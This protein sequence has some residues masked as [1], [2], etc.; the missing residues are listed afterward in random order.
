[1]A[2]NLARRLTTIVA[3]DVAGYSRLMAEDEEG[4]VRRFDSA[5]ARF[6]ALIAEHGGRIFNTAGDAVLAEFASAV[7]AARCALAVQAALEGQQAQT[8]AARRIRFRMGIHVGDVIPRGTDLLG[9]GVNVAARLQQMAP[10]GGIVIARTVS[11]QIEGKLALRLVDLGDQHVKN[12]PRPIRAYRVDGAGVPPP[13]DRRRLYA[14]LAGGGAA[15]LVL[16]AWLNRETIEAWFLPPPP[17]LPSEAVRDCPACPVMLPVRAGNFVMGAPAADNMGDD[18]ERPQRRVTIARAFLMGRTEVT[19]EQFR[20]FVRETGHQGKAECRSY[21]FNTVRWVPNPG[22]GRDDPGFPQ[23]LD[24]PA[25]CVSWDEAKAYAAWLTRKTGKTYRLP[26]E[27]E[28]EYAARGGDEGV[29]RGTGSDNQTCQYGNVADRAMAARV[30]TERWNFHDCDDGFAFTAPVAS[31]PANGF[32]LHDTIGNVWEWVEDCYVPGYERAPADGRP[33]LDGRCEDR[34]KRG[35]AWISEPRQT[36]YGAR[37][38]NDPR[39]GYTATGFRV[40]REP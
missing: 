32:N 35:G 30:R 22:I 11:E 3:A 10:P 20:H 29:R 13:P 8:P 27:A 12:I 19:V 7:N 33:R 4:T 5:R 36:R 9:D 21:N 31:R 18:A 34:V 37:S 14:G 28:W 39:V 26:S 15:L 38:F 1:M 16:L 2:E 24:H 17:P 6:D 40:A 23:G 25:V